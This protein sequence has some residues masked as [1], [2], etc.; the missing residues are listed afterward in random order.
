VKQTARVT[1]LGVFLA[2]LVVSA[3]AVSKRRDRGAVLRYF[4]SG[5]E[6]TR[7]ESGST[8]EIRG[9]GFRNWSPAWVC[10]TAGYCIQADVDASGSFTQTRSDL[11]ANATWT[12]YIDVYQWRNRSG[13]GSELVAREPITVVPHRR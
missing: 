8:V 12:Y 6:V 7:I 2:M 9:T 1:V 5:V 10:I 3:P 11:L 4:Q 13:K